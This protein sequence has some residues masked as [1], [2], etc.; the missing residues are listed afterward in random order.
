MINVS[1]N[2]LVMYLNLLRFVNFAF[3]CNK[4]PISKKFMSAFSKFFKLFFIACMALSSI[5]FYFCK[6]VKDYKLFNNKKRS[7]HAC[8]QANN[9]ISIPGVS[10]TFFTVITKSI[11]LFSICFHSCIYCFVLSGD[12]YIQELFIRFTNTRI[13]LQSST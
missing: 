13:G 10:F 5:Q 2:F 12:Y 7:W 6:H 9:N 11:F 3:Q 1:G 4:P 8:R